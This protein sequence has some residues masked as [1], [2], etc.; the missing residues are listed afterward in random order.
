MRRFLTLL[1]LFLAVVSMLAGCWTPPPRLQE[2][3]LNSRFSFCNDVPFDEYIRK[4]E[5]MIE[6]VRVD[7]NETNRDVVLDANRPFEMKPDKKKYPLDKSGRHARG[8]L[9][10]H[11]LSDSP[12]FMRAVSRHFQARGFLVRS[13][14]LPGH[15]TVPGDLLHVTYKEWIKATDYGVHQMASCV[16][17]LYMGGFSTGGALCVREALKNPKIR[18]LVLFSPAFGIKSPW[19]FMGA[20]IKVFTHWLGGERDDRDYAKYE[21]FAVNGAAQLYQL[22][23]ENDA[24][25]ASGK[26]LRLPVFSVMS[27]DDISVDTEKGLKLLSAHVLSDSS[28]FLV[29]CKSE[30]KKQAGGDIRV[31]YKNSFFPEE[32][33]A[34]FSHIALLIPPEDPHYGRQGGYK[35]CLH[36]QTDRTR[37][38]ACEHDSNVW[39]GEITGDNLKKYTLRRLTYNPRYHDMLYAL[40][41]FLE[42]VRKQGK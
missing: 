39:M 18:G 28:R 4:T 5:K 38:M 33:I 9:L 31:V 42:G 23:R 1:I 26:R 29:Y 30:K 13:I 14:L 12:Y 32:H 37:R 15:G 2:S 3:G 36:Y 40:D 21:S 27:S 41:H 17:H 25:F 19:A 20:Y 24:A 16:E 10:I 22:I 35:S 6:M 8:I 11:G 7:I 34:G